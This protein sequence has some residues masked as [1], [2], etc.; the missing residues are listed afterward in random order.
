[1]AL[2]RDLPVELVPLSTEQ[3][4]VVDLARTFAEEQIRPIAREVDD[5]DI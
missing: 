3:R 4:A 2:L 5:A 1:M